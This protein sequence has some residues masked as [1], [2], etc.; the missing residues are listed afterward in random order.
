VEAARRSRVS[1]SREQLPTSGGIRMRATASMHTL[2]TALIAS[3]MVVFCSTSSPLPTS[4]FVTQDQLQHVERRLALQERAISGLQEENAALRRVLRRKESLDAGRGS[5]RE[6]TSTDAD[7]QQRAVSDDGTTGSARRLTSTPTYLAVPTTQI[8]EFPDS[9]TCSNMG[10]NE[11]YPRLLSLDSSGPTIS[12]GTTVAS[13]DLSLASVAGKDQTVSEIQRFS[14]PL[15]I[16]H[17]SSCSNSPTLALQGN[18]QVDGSLEVAGG[19]VTV[20]GVALSGQR[21]VEKVVIGPNTAAIPSATVFTAITG[22]SKTVTL[23]AAS[24]VMMHYHIS[25]AIVAGAAS[26]GFLACQLKVDGTIHEASRAISGDTTGSTVWGTTS[27][28][29][30]DNLNVGSHTF[31]VECRNGASIDFAGDF[32]AKALQV[33]VL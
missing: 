6:S 26:S 17:D 13:S 5:V 12:P 18:T 32:Q 23:A 10:F 3:T 9:H 2:L 8:H 14:A 20:G 30:I 27:A 1:A 16:I 31:A 15:K 22:L 7:E 28:L 29:V 33:L 21:V 19:A 25:Y 4:G 11:A 24:T